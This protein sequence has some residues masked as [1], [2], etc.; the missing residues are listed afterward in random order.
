MR[1]CRVC[2]LAQLDDD[3]TDADEPRAVEPEALRLQAAEAVNR[4]E[5]AGY[6]RGA[7][8]V[9]EFGSPHGGS[10][11]PLFTSRGL[12]EMSD[13]PVDLV[14]DSFGMMHDA[15]QAAAIAR[16][17]Q[18]L[19]PGG[20]LL[21]QFHSL[22]AI[23]RQGQWNALRHGHYAYYTLTSLVPLLARAG[24]V[25]TTAWEFDLYGG[26]VLVAA[27][28]DGRSDAAVQRLRDREAA[29]G[30]ADPTVLA[31]LQ[32][33]VDLD[34]TALRDHL[35]EQKHFGRTVLGYGA[36]SRAVALLAVAGVDTDLM[37]AIAD[38]SPAKHGRRMPG[39]GVPVISP[40]DLVAAAP[41][42]VLLLLPD[43][44]PEV[45]R[46]YPALNGRWHVHPAPT[47]PSAK[48]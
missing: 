30:V 43:L 20:T 21:L 7:G 18:R 16:R 29:T 27:R 25:A 2:G 22:E 5:E 19:A 23:L 4:V 15:D 36:A 3:P 33:A 1:L 9:T 46:A 8:T 37:T 6:L 45:S 24:L 12:I 32:R 40:A 34:A 14:L 28:R 31:R 17:A 41:D 35:S 39:S 42:E 47:H 26:T 38:A 44:L 48:G 10:W 13:G 11:L